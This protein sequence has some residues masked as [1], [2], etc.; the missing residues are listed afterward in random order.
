[1][2]SGSP[3]LVTPWSPPMVMGGRKWLHQDGHSHGVRS[4]REGW[5][6]PDESSGPGLLNRPS[7]LEEEGLTLITFGL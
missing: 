3:L 2:G 5:G 6:C 7:A 4:G 1:M